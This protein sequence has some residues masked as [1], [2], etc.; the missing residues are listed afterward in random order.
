MTFIKG[1]KETKTKNILQTWIQKQNPAATERRWEEGGWGKEIKR[2]RGE[3]E[4]EKRDRERIKGGEENR[5]RR[6]RK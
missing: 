2:K 5:E 3:R 1:E 4:G 6:G